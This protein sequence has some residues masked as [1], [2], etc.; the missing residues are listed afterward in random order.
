[1]THDKSG[2]TPFLAHCQ[3][4]ASNRYAATFITDIS[5]LDT[6]TSYA[7]DSVVFKRGDWGSNSRLHTEIAHRLFHPSEFV[8]HT[9]RET[10]T[11]TITTA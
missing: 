7:K 4:S 11:L 2:Q 8:R 5:T 3:E 6:R 1:M 9:D 10:L